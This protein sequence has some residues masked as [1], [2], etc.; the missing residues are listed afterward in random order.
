MLI[1]IY[2][3]RLHPQWLTF[4]PQGPTFWKFHHFPDPVTNWQLSLQKLV[5]RDTLVPNHY[6][7]LFLFYR[8][9]NINLNP[10]VL[11]WICLIFRHQHT[12]IKS[13]LHEHLVHFRFKKSEAFLHR[14]TLLWSLL[15]ALPL[16]LLTFC[17]IGPYP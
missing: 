17:P 7:N 8:M 11:A 10:S 1:I 14:V 5:L 6:L 2:I 3:P 15:R 16:L 13:L 9:G 4:L 12:G